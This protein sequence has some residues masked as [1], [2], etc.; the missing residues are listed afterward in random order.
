MGSSKLMRMKCSQKNF[1]ALPSEFVK[2]L[3]KKIQWIMVY[4]EVGVRLANGITPS[5]AI[6]IPIRPTAVPIVTVRNMNSNFSA[7]PK[8]APIINTRSDRISY[9]KITADE[10]DSIL[11]RFLKGDIDAHERDLILQLRAGGGFTDIVA[12]IAF[13]IFVNWIDSLSKVKAFQANPL[14]HMDPLGWLSGKYDSKNAGNP[15]CRSNLPS[16]FE[17]ET[18]HTMKQM[19]AASVDENGFVMSYDEAYNLIKET[20]PD[21]MQ[22]TEDFKI[23][24]WQAASHLYHGKGVDVNPEDFGITQTE[25]DKIREGGFIK[26]VQ[27]GNK[28]PS[29]EHVRT[30]QK[31]LKDI[32]LDPST[33]RRD[34]SEYYNPHGVTPTTVFKNGRY[35]VCFNQTTGDLITGDKQRRGTVNKFDQTNKIGSKKWI[36]KWSK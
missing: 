2:K 6:G 20:Y 11:S 18:L 26:Y 36:D 14:P 24:D 33:D 1:A 31:S 29:I 7:K 19:C 30:Y 35:L 13:V 17:R 9:Q 15:Q 8:I 32:C 5:Q 25:L 34:D 12:I 3:E 27:K 22:I 16:R 21:S 23:T 4:V 28:L 10:F